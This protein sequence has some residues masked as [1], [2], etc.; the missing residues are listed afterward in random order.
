[1]SFLH[2]RLLGQRRSKRSDADTFRGIQSEKG[3][4]VAPDDD[5]MYSGC[6]SG[7]RCGR[8]GLVPLT[9]RGQCNERSLST[10]VIVTVLLETN[11]LTE[12]DACVGENPLSAT[13][14]EALSVFLVSCRTFKAWAWGLI[15]G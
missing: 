15:C 3:T 13:R 8:W 14:S 4:R 5:P 10:D 11:F 9:T 12:A 1:V 2:M 7:R 6:L